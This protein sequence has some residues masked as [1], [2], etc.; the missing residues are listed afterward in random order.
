MKAYLAQ[1]DQLILV[2]NAENAAAAKGKKA[3]VEEEK[4]E[5]GGDGRGDM[6]S[7]TSGTIKSN[8]KKTDLTKSAFTSQREQHKMSNKKTVPLKVD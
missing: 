5:E 7:K 2:V 6:N 1:R 4:K 3:P 8:L